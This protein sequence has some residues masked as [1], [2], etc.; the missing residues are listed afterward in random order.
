MAIG[1][2]DALASAAGTAPALATAS[3]PVWLTVA[4]RVWAVPVASVRTI[5]EAG[6]VTPLPIVVPWV[7]GI[8]SV[9]DSPV[10]CV[11]L[12][13]A[14]GLGS[15]SSSVSGAGRRG[16]VV[17]VV[18]TV[19]GDVALRVDDARWAREDSAPVLELADLLPWCGGFRVVGRVESAAPSVCAPQVAERSLL[20][21]SQEGGGELAL[22]LDRLDRIERAEPVA[23]LPDS[24]AWLVAVGGGLLPGRTLS[25]RGDG[26]RGLAGH[27]VVLR[28]DAP[29]ERAALLVDR[30]IGVER[31]P[32]DALFAVRHPDG[33]GSVWWRRADAPP[34]RVVDP[35]PL[36]GWSP[37]DDAATESA[38]ATLTT[39]DSGGGQPRWLV[40]ER[41]GVAVAI[42]LALVAQV[43]SGGAGRGADEAAGAADRV[44]L[45][46][47]GRWRRHPLR[48]DR[49]N[50]LDGGAAAWRSVQ[51]APPVVAALFDAARFDAT[52]GR[53]TFRLK[54]DSVDHAP[55]GLPW[56]VR[57]LLVAAWRDWVDAGWRDGSDPV[58]A[59]TTMS[60]P[61]FAPKPSVIAKT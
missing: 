23:P 48:V 4:G 60:H 20:R 37:A 24:S 25:E 61:D 2:S 42:P 46:G 28:G 19:V 3:L 34:L 1:V 39:R 14:L 49:V 50:A 15:E 36:F 9:N 18:A 45:A 51:G 57:R 56:P 38:A 16:R 35:G 52:T 29:G 32:P 7:D 54:D 26:A 12:V 31:C 6:P 13:G 58:P 41:E 11:D 43:T 10:V 22:R 47:P 21:V 55:R 59:S 8:A 27:A 5:A 40:V 33:G 44:R 17:V 30:A 53:W